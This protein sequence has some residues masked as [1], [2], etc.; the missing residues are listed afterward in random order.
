MYQTIFW[1][2]ILCEAG[3]V[4]LSDQHQHLDFS[5]R[6]VETLCHRMKSEMYKLA[7]ELVQLTTKFEFKFTGNILLFVFINQPLG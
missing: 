1:V 6:F 2:E 7:E 5:L 3:Q 4:L